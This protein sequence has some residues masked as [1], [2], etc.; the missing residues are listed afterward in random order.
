MAVHH[1]GVALGLAVL[2]ISERGLGHQSPQSGFVG[3][4]GE[5]RELL[6]GDRK[7]ATKLHQPFGH[8][9]QPLFEQRAGH[10]GSLG[11]DRGSGFASSTARRHG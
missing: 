9:S 11:P 2:A 8:I 10:P 4:V 7:L 3:L 6:I 5:V 1:I